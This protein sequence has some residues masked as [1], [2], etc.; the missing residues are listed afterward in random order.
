[1]NFKKGGVKAAV[2]LRRRVNL[3][4]WYQAVTIPLIL[5]AVAAASFALMA[6]RNEW[7]TW[8]DCFGLLRDSLH[9]GREGLPIGGPVGDG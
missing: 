3:A 5:V 7:S 8:E 1:M 9:W 4:W 6:R 2:G